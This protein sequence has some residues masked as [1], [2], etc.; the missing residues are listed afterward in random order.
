MVEILMFTSMIMAMLAWVFVLRML[1][2]YDGSSEYA[3]TN[4]EEL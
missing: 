1:L 4:I 3:Y 2:L